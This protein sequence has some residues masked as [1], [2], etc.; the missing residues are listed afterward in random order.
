MHDLSWN[1][2]T[3]HVLHARALPVKDSL[4]VTFHVDVADHLRGKSK[5]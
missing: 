3:F 4:Q 1:L 5:G 2:H